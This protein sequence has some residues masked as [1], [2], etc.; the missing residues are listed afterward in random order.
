MQI[1]SKPFTMEKLS[2]K[3]R[4]MIDGSFDLANQ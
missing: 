4:E 3:I 2:T 1:I